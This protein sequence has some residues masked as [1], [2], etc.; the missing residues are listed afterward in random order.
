MSYL[1]DTDWVV[2]HLKGRAPAVEVLPI[3]APAGLTISLITIGEVYEGIYFGHD[4]RR[5]ETIFREFLHGVRVLPLHQ[6]IMRRFG[7][8]RGEL[9]RQG[10]R[11]GDPDLLIAATALHYNQVLVTHNTDHFQRIPDLQL[12]R[13]APTTRGER[14]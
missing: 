8:L 3:L 5:Q 14:S 12:Y 6:T 7:R 2:E 11:I 4:P 9:R 1:I 13:H 10:Q